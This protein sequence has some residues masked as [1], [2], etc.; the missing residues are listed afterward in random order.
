MPRYP[1]CDPCQIENTCVDKRR[2]SLIILHSSSHTRS[3]G[4]KTFFKTTPAAGLGT[5]FL[6]PPRL[7]IP[8]RVCMQD[9][10]VGECATCA[11]MQ[12]DASTTNSTEWSSK[13]HSVIQAESTPCKQDQKARRRR[14]MSIRRYGLHRLAGRRRYMSI[15]RY[16][17]HRLAGR[18]RYMSIRRY[19]LHR[20]AARRHPGCGH[21]H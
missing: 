11:T 9:A 13:T 14:Y 10:W 12:M 1:C 8:T 20:L 18:R 15:R 4:L 7:V 6:L 5:Y 17:L 2:I 21:R 3:C 19:G 16:G